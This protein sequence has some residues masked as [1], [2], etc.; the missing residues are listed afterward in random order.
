M[1]KLNKSGWD[2][3]PTSYETRTTASDKQKESTSTT[4]NSPQTG[5]NTDNRSNT[6]NSKAGRT[7]Q[8]HQK[9][10]KSYNTRQDK[11][12]STKNS[13]NGSTNGDVKRT[14]N[15]TSNRNNNSKKYKTNNSNRRESIT[16]QDV[17]ATKP[18]KAVVNTSPKQNIN[19]NRNSSQHQSKTQTSRVNK[20]KQEEINVNTTAG[21]STRVTTGTSTRVTA[22]ASTKAKH[23][24]LCTLSGTKQIG[25][26][27]NFVEYGDDIVIVD[28]GFNFPGQDLLGIDYT[29]P[30]FTYL[31]RNKHKIRGIVITHGHLDHI[32]G[33][34]YIMEMLDFPTIYAGR[35]AKA[36]INERL[37]ES[38]LDKKTTIEAVHRNTKI[39]L[40][41]FEA[42]FIGVTH[43][44][45]NSFSI[46]ISS[47]AG[48]IF[49]SGDY[50]IDPTPSGEEPTDLAT[51]KAVGPS[52]DLA[53][54]EST[55]PEQ[56]G[57]SRSD[58]EVKENLH[59]L[60]AAHKGRVIVSAFASL[61]SRL[62]SLVQI[63]Q[64]TD[65]K[66]AVAGR[67]LVT[68]VRIIRE[69][70]YLTFPENL[71]ITEQEI[72]KYPDNKVLFVCTGSQGERYAALNRISLGEHKYLKAKKGDLIIMSSSEIPGNES[73]I[74]KMTDRLLETG[75]D[76]IQNNI[77]DVHGSG[78][79]Y[80]G[81]MKQMYETLKP[82]QVMPV[83]G[84]LTKRYKNKLNLIRWGMKDDKIHL[85]TDGAIWT[86]FKTTDTW[87]K[88]SNI[89]ASQI[90]IDGLGIGDISEIVLQDRD[91]LSQFG[92][93]T[94]VLNL[95]A[96]NKQ[97]I[98]K[99][100]FVSRGFVY[101]K[102]S[103]ELF[104]E[105]ELIVIDKHKVWHTKAQ[106]NNRFEMKD[107]YFDIEK[108]IKHYI[109]KKTER[110]PLVLPVFI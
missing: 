76:L 108:S 1:K 21:T 44:I 91:T 10:Q 86:Y 12:Y 59:K 37:K 107:L 98:G 15:R 29:L 33:L 79:G 46:M 25:S 85:T 26:N 89:E 106:K 56:S 24:K 16:R 65:R 55:N 66:I 54:M 102:N 93:V 32:G 35:Y 13:K 60:I 73:V 40:G 94:I 23:L 6:S 50:K 70:N 68:A 45:P 36:L 100:R 34:A 105:L 53:L 39:Q 8:R 88:T 17:G 5:S 90:L 87:K 92:M 104:K 75:A 80:Q 22:R 48:N 52:V 72:V 58:K 69:L 64:E 78:H 83:H 96:K 99:P 82:R 77:A 81:D 14:T 42:H 19:S 51:I 97:I 103:K 47:K 9:V 95:S 109:Y 2:K 84:S 62:Y 38:K 28:Y 43:S 7:A 41:V 71:L 63:A 3:T 110:E 61:V 101:V 74:E 27:C 18:Q 11:S 31:K 20:P 67:S 30:N 57:F 49:F 4:Q